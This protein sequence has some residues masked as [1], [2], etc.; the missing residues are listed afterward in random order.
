[1]KKYPVSIIVWFFVIVTSLVIY[2]VLSKE[3]A[4]PTL[5]HKQLELSLARLDLQRRNLVRNDAAWFYSSLAVIS[6]MCLSLVIV[7]AGVHRERVKKAAVHTYKIGQSEIVIHERDLSAAWQIVIGLVNAEEL[8]AMNGGLEKALQLQT[9]I[10]DQQIRNFQALLGRHGLH[11]ALPPAAVPIAPATP[12]N[13]IA[14]PVP[15]FQ[16][17][18]ERGDIAP[19]K[20]MILGFERG[21]PRRGSFLDIYSAAIAGESGSGKTITLLYLIGS[22]IVSCG[23]KFVV[24]DPHDPHPKALGPKLKPLREKGLITVATEKKAMFQALQTVE[25]ILDRRLAQLDQEVTP[26]VLVLDELTLLSKMS[27][28]PTA[29]R[30]MERI[31]TEGRKAAVYLLASSQTWLAART[32]ETSIVR[33]TLT[34]AYVHRIKPKQAS[35]LLQDKDEVDKVRTLKDVGEVLLCPVGDD[36]CI[37]KIPYTSKEDMTRIAA[38][39][40][41]V[42]HDLNQGNQ[43]ENQADSSTPSI[44]EVEKATG[45][46]YSALQRYFD[47][48][49][50]LKT[51]YKAKYEAYLFQRNQV[52]S[53][54][55]SIESG[56][57]SDANQT[58]VIQ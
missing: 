2:R 41:Q 36:S 32:G 7:A 45:I 6:T 1:M 23:V 43:A 27:I 24:L 37:C 30:V 26:V 49:T 3:A 57:E 34:S 56:D 13:V 18:L 21:R 52:E 5:Q 4:A 47:K 42:N 35:I 9:I 16:Q 58:K 19:G 22:G 33:D 17:L 44:R 15:T 38:M 8:K 12:G 20:P 10:A 46:P 53:V 40:H 25:T 31:S 11:P 29:F 55:K 48:G 14:E 50:P 28:G 51:E 39:P 54:L